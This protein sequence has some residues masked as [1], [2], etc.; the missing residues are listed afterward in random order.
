MSN[1]QQPNGHEINSIGTLFSQG[2]MEECL[3]LASS[4][5]AKYPK[6]PMLANMLGVITAK[7]GRLDEALAYYN[8][9]LAIKPGYP[10]AYNNMGNTLNRLGRVDEAVARFSS[11]IK[12]NPM[13][14]EPHNNLG[15]LLLDQGDFEKAYSCYK[16]AL[17]IKP[18]YA[19][20][21]NGLGNALRGLDK[22]VDAL[23]SFTAA[24]KISPGFAQAHKNKGDVLRTLGK[25]E[26]AA[27]SFKKAIQFN[28]GYFGPYLGLGLIFHDLGKHQK[29]VQSLKMAIRLNPQSAMAHSSL[30]NALGECGLHDEATACYQQALLIDPSFADAHCYL[31]NSLSALGNYEEAIVHFTKALQIKPDLSEAHLN[32]ARLKK[33]HRDD[34]QFKEMLNRLAMP[35]I[36]E[37]ERTLLSF[38]LGKAYEDLD[39]VDLSFKYLAEGNRLRRNAFRY[40]IGE[41]REKFRKIK[42]LYNAENAEY[43]SRE[44]SDWEPSIQPIFIVGMLRSGTT[45]VEQILASHSK[46]T[47][48]GELEVL[49]RMLN[50]SVENSST[51]EKLS[52]LIL[53]QYREDFLA[54][55]AELPIA[56]PWATDK[57]P[58]NYKWIGFLLTV[59]PGVKIVHVNRD[60]VA[61]CWS[62]FKHQFRGHGFTNDLKDL[63][64]HYKLYLDLMAFWRKNFPGQIYDLEYEALTENQKP[65]TERLLQYCGLCWEEQCLEFYK[66]KRSVRTLSDAQVR[67][68][69]YT[70][71]SE[72]WRKYEKNLQP[73]IKELGDQSG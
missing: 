59:M 34:S 44:A 60:P 11:A 12:N 63:G 14:A 72:D 8:K 49:E 50:P 17:S 5:L 56:T 20:A 30:G 33:Y 64:E 31:G 6:A 37:H 22:P 2:R 48:C 41:D 35:D 42:S 70:G 24:L 43:Y 27:A 57:M 3:D 66:T 51:A 28:P 36:S 52:G 18:N 53:T 16:K 46:V 19:E 62:M 10:E 68:K 47:G 69:I 39:E 13:Y 4:L 54:H 9:A 23:A 7:M 15:S 32:Q 65:E 21:H 55:L 58:S 61:T 38:A 67:Q 71:S 73:L 25:F 1:Y 29:A 40:N 26:E 45:L